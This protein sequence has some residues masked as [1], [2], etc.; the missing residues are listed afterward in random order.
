MPQFHFCSFSQYN[1]AMRHNIRTRLSFLI[2][3]ALFTVFQAM[4]LYSQNKFKSSLLQNSSGTEINQGDNFPP[5]QVA[6]F[7]NSSETS[8]PQNS[9]PEILYASNFP[10][11]IKILPPKEF[12]T[13]KKPDKK[14]SHLTRYLRSVIKKQTLQ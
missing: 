11:S 8:F 2:F 14:I 4:S 13:S 3:T 5:V 9:E 12:K 1:K 7:E 10:F 6:K